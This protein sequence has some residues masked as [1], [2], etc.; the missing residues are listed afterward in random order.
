M[1]S[2]FTPTRQDMTCEDKARQ[3]RRHNTREN[4]HD[5]T[6]N[7]AHDTTKTL[8]S[9]G[10]SAQSIRS[11]M[12]STQKAKRQTDRRSRHCYTRVFFV[13]SAFWFP[14]TPPIWDRTKGDGRSNCPHESFLAA[15]H[16]FPFQDRAKRERERERSCVTYKTNRLIFLQ[17]LQQRNLPS[18]T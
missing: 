9:F 8:Y 6:I 11:R 1:R 5:K 17:S 2:Q 3:A 18:C 4:R 10:P 15:L 7:R 16:R 12:E 13:F 14:S